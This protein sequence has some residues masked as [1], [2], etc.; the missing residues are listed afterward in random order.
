MLEESILITKE[1]DYKADN[2]DE[3]DSLY[4]QVMRPANEPLLTFVDD[5]LH[6]LS[7][8]AY[9][10]IWRAMGLDPYRR[11]SVNGLSIDEFLEIIK[12]DALIYVNGVGKVTV[13]EI[14][15][16]F[17]DNS[18]VQSDHAQNREAGETGD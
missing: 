7:H 6:R 14:R 16:A 15:G 11:G 3:W 9:R 1:K 17:L 10:G 18:E 5:N 12:T 4:V 8:R 13:Q 2:E